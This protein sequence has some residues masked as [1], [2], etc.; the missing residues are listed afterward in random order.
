M[1][2][3][4]CNCLV[5]QPLKSLNKQKNSCNNKK[6]KKEIFERILT[7]LQINLQKIKREYNFI[8]LRPNNNHEIKQ[9]KKK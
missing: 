6:S 5:K 3:K 4:S 2:I 8:S 1:K 7:F 9:N